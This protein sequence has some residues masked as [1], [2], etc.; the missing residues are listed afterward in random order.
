MIQCTRALDLVYKPV[1][2]DEA[3]KVIYDAVKTAVERVPGFRPGDDISINFRLQNGGIIDAS[4][5]RLVRVSKNIREIGKSYDNEY[6]IK[7][8]DLVTTI[9]TDLIISIFPRLIEFGHDYNMIAT[10][11]TWEKQ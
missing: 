3:R 1:M 10:V 7:D 6:F 4:D 2:N 8:T 5:E 9:F 11:H